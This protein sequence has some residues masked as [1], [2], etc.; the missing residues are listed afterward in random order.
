MAKRGRVRIGTSGWIYKHWRG[1]VYPPRVPV[2]DWFAEYAGQFD[3]VEINNSFYRL[4]ADET[5]RT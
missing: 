3:T 4:P 1:V 5:F 2:R